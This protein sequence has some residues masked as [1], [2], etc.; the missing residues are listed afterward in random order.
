[1]QAGAQ[2]VAQKGGII[3]RV[4]GADGRTA[5]KHIGIRA[6]GAQKAAVEV[7]CP[8]PNQAVHI[9]HAPII[10]A[11]FAHFAQALLAAVG[12]PIQNGAAVAGLGGAVF[13]GGRSLAGI[14]PLV[15][16]GQAFA[17]CGAIGVGGKPRYV[18][19]RFI[20]ITGFGCKA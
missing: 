10:G 5:A 9:V 15:D 18:G 4:G 2:T 11:A 20:G 1:M 13:A 19:D 7:F 17:L 12:I 14:F 8:F 3:A 6:A 16:G